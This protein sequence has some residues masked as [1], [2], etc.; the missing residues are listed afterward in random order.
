MKDFEGDDCT[1]STVLPALVK[2]TCPSVANLEK[3]TDAQKWFKKHI[4]NRL[5]I[6]NDAYFNDANMCDEL[7]TCALVHP[8][9]KDMTW[10]EGMYGPRNVWGCYSKV[11]QDRK[12]PGR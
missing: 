5:A 10:L 8:Q 12:T 6:A 9:V 7:A 1:I 4:V 3:M 2:W 11:K